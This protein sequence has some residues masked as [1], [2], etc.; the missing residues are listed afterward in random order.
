M[1]V[2]FTFKL[3]YDVIF[4]DPIIPG[5]SLIYRSLKEK[6]HIKKNQKIRQ[7]RKLLNTVKTE[8]CSE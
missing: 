5:R 3:R 1:T 4:Y 2:V 6:E 7:Q 8:S